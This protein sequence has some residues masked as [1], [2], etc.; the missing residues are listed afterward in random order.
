MVKP[1]RVSRGEAPHHRE[2]IRAFDNDALPFV[3]E[4][5]ELLAATTIVVPLFKRFRQSSI[6]G[7]LFAGVVLGPHGL[8]LVKDVA[9]ITELAEF[10]VLFLLFEMGLQLS[11][12]RLRKLRRFV[13]GMGTLQMTLSTALFSFAAHALTNSSFPESVTIGAALSL[14]SSAFVLS[15]LSEKGE[16]ATRTGTASTGV[17]LLQDIAT[18][19]LLV[20]IPL[21]S[22]H[23][24]IEPHQIREAIISSAGHVAKTL[25]ILNGFILA[26]GFVMRRIF[27]LVAESKSSEAFTSSTLLTVLGTAWFTAELGLPMT[28]GSFIAGVLLAES[29]FRS[30][31]MVDMEPFRGLLLGLFFITT[32]MTLNPVLL[33]RPESVILVLGLLLTKTAL[34]SVSGLAVGLSLA[35]S[36]RVGLLT[37]QGGE[38]SFVMFALAKQ[39]GFLPDDLN[40]YLTTIVVATMALTPALYELGL[41]VS[42]LVDRL[43]KDSGGETTPETVLKDIEESD[44]AFV[45]IFGWGPVGT[46]VG[47]MLS[48]KFIRW[49]S[50]DI[51]LKLVQEGVEA[52]LPVIYGD[53]LHPV[54]LLEANGLPTPSAFVI[55]HSDKE[56]AESCLSALRAS[57]PD[58]PVYVRAKDILQQERLLNLGA[59][60]I[61]PESLETSIS[62]GAAVLDGFGTQQ[63]DVK[64]IKR[65][66][67]Q[68]GD[69]EKAFQEYESN[70]KEIIRSPAHDLS[71]SRNGEGNGTVLSGNSVAPILKNVSPK[72]IEEV[73]KM[74]E[75]ST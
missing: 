5:L 47:R 72:P 71:A 16:R 40:A 57:F 51:N 61:Y 69:V 32:G 18:V 25:T 34:T 8:R 37:S 12:D 15:I 29:S 1:G 63:S 19:P 48:R 28:L 7:F 56:I 74:N 45:L 26:G 21:L 52:D 46:V 13:F 64:A 59:M 31:I 73:A 14:S 27:T 58:R 62:L 11:L 10:G 75:D 20:L 65:E 44:D 6:L 70:W 67:R 3:G 41:R 4:A 42:P 53:S 66:M 38:F 43:V 33:L 36:T 2:T 54:E 9:D 23:V 49:V 50:V 55:T 39:L 68:N 35:E 60:A 30:R 17:L 24:S 22:T